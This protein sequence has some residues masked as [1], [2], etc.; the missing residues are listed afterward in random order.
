MAIASSRA[1]ATTVGATGVGSSTGRAPHS[2]AHPSHRSTG[3]PW[4]APDDGA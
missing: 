1:S 4:K 2:T 3:T